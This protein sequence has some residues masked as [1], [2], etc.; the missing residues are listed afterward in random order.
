MMR[1]ERRDHTSQATALVH[2]AVARLLDKEALKESSDPNQ[3]LAAVVRAMRQILVN[4][5]RRRKAGMRGGGRARVTLD[6]VLASV[7]EQGVDINDLHEALERLAQAYPRP[8]QVVELRFI[9]GLS[10]PK[11][12][13]ILG[14]CEGTVESD[15][16]IARAWLHGQ[17]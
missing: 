15:W 3:V 10:I 2:E 5:A 7:E 17:L 12:A 13:K 6:E 8:A 16:R 1:R 14:V 9:G 4:H 11:V